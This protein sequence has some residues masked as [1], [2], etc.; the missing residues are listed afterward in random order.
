[1]VI[2]SKTK[3]QDID[4]L[5]D[6]ST[7]LNSINKDDKKPQPMFPKRFSSYVHYLNIVPRSIEAGEILLISPCGRLGD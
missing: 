2:Q 5:G 1:M 7:T 4:S 3:I 6:S